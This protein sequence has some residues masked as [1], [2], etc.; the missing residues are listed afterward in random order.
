V[1]LVLGFR[2]HWFAWIDKIHLFT[3]V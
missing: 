2:L 3:A 1:R